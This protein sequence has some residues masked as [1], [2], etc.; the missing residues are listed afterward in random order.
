MKV[1]ISGGGTGGHVFP[2]IAI[3]DALKKIDAT[4]EILFVGA[5]GKLE[6]EKVPKAGYPIKGL[7]ISG[8]QRKI[9]FKNFVNLFH[10]LG[11]LWKS[12]RILGQFQ[13]DVVVGVGGYA[14]GPTLEMAYRKGLP[15]LVQEQNSYAGITNKLLAKKA[16]KICVAYSNMERFFPKHKI[17]LTGNPVRKD[18]G[19]LAHLKEE[20]L[21]YFGLEK[22]KKT[23]LLFGGS[24]GAKSLN[25]AMRFNWEE[26]GQLT[27]VQVLWQV[28][29]LYIEEYK[30]CETA[31][32]PNVQVRPFLD[33]MDLVYALADV[34]ICRAGALT[35][36]ELSMV[37]KPAV[38][39]PS[40]NVAE[41]HQTANAK[42]LEAV[43][44][45]ILVED[46]VATE[47][48]LPEA[49]HILRNNTLSRQLSQQIKSLA[50]PNAAMEIAQ[51][52][53]KLAKN[54]VIKCY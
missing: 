47:K 21:A 54:E 27:D 13:P 22:G 26:I 6:M 44:A 9:S 14:S 52:V 12:Y 36:S 45:A 38:L 5:E 31:Q 41:D 8:F 32:L 35:I 11:S 29:K 16:N 53:M 15:I 42:A 30:D 48:M 24:L 18:I 3:A 2:A 33:R 20:G 37:G 1:I 23:I 43:S 51:E 10:L 34:V 40:P 25:I 50:K 7:R 39:V 19:N 46:S 17:Q 4:I 49:I 28:G